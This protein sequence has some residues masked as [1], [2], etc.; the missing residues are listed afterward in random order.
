M[1]YITQQ[2]DMLDAICH[3]YYQGDISTLGAV[4]AANPGLANHGALLP[5]GLVIELPTIRAEENLQR[6]TLWD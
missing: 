6:I 2:N 5:A 4:L 3:R 1:K